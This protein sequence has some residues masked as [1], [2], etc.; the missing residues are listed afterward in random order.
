MVLV[1]KLFIQLFL[2]AIGKSTSKSEEAPS[3]AK[4]FYKVKN[5]QNIFELV[6]MM[7]LFFYLKEVIK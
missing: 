1:I 3:Q 6:Q 7:P 5:M 4:A 2:E